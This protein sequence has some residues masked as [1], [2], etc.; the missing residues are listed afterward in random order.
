MLL[1][2]DSMS[3][4]AHAQREIGLAIGE[5]PTSRVIPVGFSL[6]QSHRAHRH[7]IKDPGGITAMYTLLAEGDDLRDPVVDWPGHR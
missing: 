7:R 5:P 6:L 3:R 4:V 2:V 1:L